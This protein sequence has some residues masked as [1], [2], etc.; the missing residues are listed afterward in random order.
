M[1]STFYNP[2]YVVAVI[3]EVSENIEEDYKPN[4]DYLNTFKLI[5]STYEKD[6]S[7]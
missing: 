4:V 6:H 3:P 5:A 1:R 7:K 2:N